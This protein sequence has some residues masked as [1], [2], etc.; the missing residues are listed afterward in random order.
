VV[1]PVDRT[2]KLYIGG[3]QVRPD[4]GYSLAVVAR[5]GTRIGEVG[6][7]NR[8]DIRNAVEAAH[9]AAAWGRATAHTRAQ[10]LYYLAENLE[11]RAGELAARLD[12]M[13]GAADGSREVGAAAGRLF[14]WAA[15]A[16]KW[17]GRVHHTPYRNV[18]LAMPEP[19]GVIGIVCPA[20]VPLLGFVSLVAP[21]IA[22]GNTVVAVPSEPHPLAATDF[23]Q[24]LDTSDVPGGVVNLVTGRRD[25]LAEV[26]AAHDD[27]DAVWYAGSADGQAAVERLSAGNL[28]RTWTDLDRVGDWYDDGTASGE[29]FLRAAT[30]IK[31][32]WIPYGD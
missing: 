14:T 17:D 20:G 25:E 15:W 7:G 30:Q 28:K 18:T 2:A 16:D 13:T 5:D 6:L 29:R 23:Y 10:V 31:N 4:G 21:A 24:V 3:K 1:P 11:A 22:M 12:A 27:V 8:K 9:A 26:L 19:I 32:I